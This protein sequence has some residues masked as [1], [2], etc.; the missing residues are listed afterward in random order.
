MT[1]HPKAIMSHV[2]YREDPKSTE[3]GP[4]I[5]MRSKYVMCTNTYPSQ[6]RSTVSRHRNKIA[7]AQNE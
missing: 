7:E 1:E 2:H 4:S 6:F 3:Y 5:L